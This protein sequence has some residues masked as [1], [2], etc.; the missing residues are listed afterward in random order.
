MKNTILSQ[1]IKKTLLTEQFRPR[2]DSTKT[3]KPI[4]TN[5]TATAAAKAKAKAKAAAKAKADAK[6]TADAK[7]SKT[8]KIKPGTDYIVNPPMLFGSKKPYM[9]MIFNKG[10]DGKWRFEYYDAVTKTIKSGEVTGDAVLAKLNSANGKLEWDGMYDGQNVTKTEWFELMAKYDPAFPGVTEVPMLSNESMTTLAVVGMWAV[11]GIG[12][13]AGLRYGW[14]LIK[15]FG[16]PGADSKMELASLSGLSKDGVM[17][18]QQWTEYQY[19]IGKISKTEKNQLQ[20]IY[21][22]SKYRRVVPTNVF[23]TMK[24]EVIRG[25]RTMAELITVMP[26]AYREQ[27]GLVD[28]LLKYERDVLNMYPGR[29]TKWLVAAEKWAKQQSLTRTEIKKLF[30]GLGLPPLKTKPISQTN[31]GVYDFYTN[32]S[33]SGRTAASS[34]AKTAMDKA[35]KAAERAA[36]AKAATKAS[37]EA[38]VD[39][40]VQRT[41]GFVKQ[42]RSQKLPVTKFDIYSTPKNIVD[43]WEMNIGSKTLKGKDISNLRDDLAKLSTEKKAI[44]KIK[45]FAV[46]HNWNA[47]YSKYIETFL[48]N[49]LP[50]YR[51]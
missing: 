44:E 8:K 10:S 29:E 9:H 49:M 20:G 38:M 37:I 14:K 23:N 22:N 28:A 35:I 30:P 18:M 32:T 12:L 3:T 39:G 51:K 46:A 43:Q 34:D 25:D 21:R 6:A 27:K 4:S 50:Y 11:K 13:I 16:K 17:S 26:E 2:K 7:A 1:I 45:A 31:P 40:L 19:G 5:I 48:Q 42:R 41:S 15:W 36:K 33:T 24:N 47:N